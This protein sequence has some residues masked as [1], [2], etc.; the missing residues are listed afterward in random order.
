MTTEELNI[1][2]TADTSGATSNIGKAEKSVNELG[3][4]SKGAADK[5]DKLDKSVTTTGG[6]LRTF[7]Q[8]ADTAGNRLQSLEGKANGLNFSGLKSTLVGLGL[9]KML[10]DS[11]TN[12]MDAVESESLFETSLGGLSSQAR[13][14]SE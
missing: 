8:E 13:S 4:S 14:W 12:A 7:G 9:G 6:S 10:K 2:I 11:I 3:K 1:K 5:I